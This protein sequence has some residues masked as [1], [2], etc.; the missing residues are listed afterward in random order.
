MIDNMPAGRWLLFL[1]KMASLQEYFSET[2][3]PLNCEFV[4]AQPSDWTKNRGFEVSLTEVFHVHPSR[5]VQTRHIGKWSSSHG[6][7]WSTESFFERRGDLQGV[8]IE[9]GV[10]SKVCCS[11]NNNTYSWQQGTNITETLTTNQ[12]FSGLPQRYRALQRENSSKVLRRN[13][14]DMAYFTRSTKLHVSKGLT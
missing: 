6:L 7:T 9:S 4:V 12:F 1:N 3:I 11:C 2:Y 10:Q 5:P 8:L 14:R 13:R